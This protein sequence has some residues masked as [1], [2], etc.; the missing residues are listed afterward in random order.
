MKYFKPNMVLQDM[1]G[2]MSTCILLFKRVKLA[3][4]IT[5]ILLASLEIN[6]MPILH[7]YCPG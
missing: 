6:T 2:L 3:C 1:C 4:L 7:T 5:L